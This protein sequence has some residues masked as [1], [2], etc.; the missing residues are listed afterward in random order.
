MP[1]FNDSPTEGRP[2]KPELETISIELLKM[3]VPNKYQYVPMAVPIASCDPSSR[4]SKLPSFPP[5]PDGYTM[6]QNPIE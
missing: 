1:P 5:Y 2:S 3:I 4:Y 6:S